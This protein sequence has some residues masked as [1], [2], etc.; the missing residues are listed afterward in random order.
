MWQIY[1]G[2]PAGTL[3]AILSRFTPGLLP[4][5]PVSRLLGYLLQQS[6]ATGSVALHLQGDGV[7]LLQLSRDL[8]CQT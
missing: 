1:T 8:H 3:E 7:A 2:K 4:G 6:E 5:L